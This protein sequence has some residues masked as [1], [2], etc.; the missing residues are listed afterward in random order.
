MNVKAKSRPRINSGNVLLFK[1]IAIVLPFIV[2]LI[3]ELSLR[4]AG[5]GNDLSLFLTD[6]TGKYYYLNPQIGK[7]Y[8]TQEVNATNGNMDFFRK[9]K[10][11]GTLRI[12]VLGSS[13]AIGFPYMYNGAFP[14][15]LNYRLQR[16]YPELNIEMINLSLTAINSYAV[17][18]MAKEL[19]I[20]RAHV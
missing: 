11:P 20:G 2:L 15:M 4:V 12:F 18:D 6:K 13:T 7:R 14:R 16:H 17:L 8:F 19:E 5:Y 9:D 1:I 10:T 3:A